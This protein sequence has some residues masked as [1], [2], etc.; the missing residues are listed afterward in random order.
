MHKAGRMLAVSNIR[1]KVIGIKKRK[2]KQYKKKKNII[3]NQD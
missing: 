3:N 2:I 1:N